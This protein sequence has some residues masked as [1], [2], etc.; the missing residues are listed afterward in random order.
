MAFELAPAA[1]IR[2]AAWPIE[3]LDAFGDRELAELVRARSVT[4]AEYERAIDRERAALWERSAGDPRF[5]KALALASPSLWQRVRRSDG[6]RARRTK[7]V[8]HLETSLYRYLA[9]AAARPT[10]A[11]LWAG[12][13]TARFGAD[14]AVTPSDGAVVFTPDLVPFASALHALEERVEYRDRARFRLSPTLRQQAD[15]SY[16]FLARA[17]GG[18][19]DLRRIEPSP[20]LGGSFDRLG[21]AGVG[22]LSELAER[23][24]LPRSVLDQLA[25]DGVLVGGLFPTS[26]ASAWEALER[27]EESLLGGDQAAWKRSLSALGQVASRLGTDFDR[28][29]AEALVLGV[30]EARTVVRGLLASLGLEIEVPSPAMH[31]DLAL[32]FVVTLG[33]ATHAELLASLTLYERERLEAHPMASAWQLRRSALAE[34]MARAPI[35]LGDELPPIFPQD[36]ARTEAWARAMLSATDEIRLHSAE[37]TGDASDNPWGSWVARLGK[38]RI[39]SATAIDESPLRPFARHAPMLGA[40]NEITSWVA[41]LFAKLEADHGV[42]AADLAVPFERNPNVLARPSVA[43]VTLEPWGAGGSDLRGA[44]FRS[45]AGAIVLDLPS[46]GRV[47]VVTSFS[48]N[49]LALDPLAAALALTGFAEPVDAAFQLPERPRATPEDAPYPSPR[50]VLSNGTSIR[51]RSTLLRGRA[52]DELAATPRNERYGRWRKLAEQLAWGPC[53]GL[54]VDGGPSLVLDASSPLAVEAAFEGARQARAILVE[55]VDVSARIRGRSGHHV[56]D[57]VVPF[58]RTPHA[59]S[60]CKG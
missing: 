39:T 53:V 51:P 29:S 48:A 8:R 1:V 9:R 56:A 10:P 43:R 26:F 12:V 30:E 36:E 14:D 59:F 2:A 18:S 47:I 20:G 58:S 11:G 27:A 60:A 21:D 28:L 25:K 23:S 33:P 55:E 41:G 24:R 49:A 22:T 37:R 16:Q 45:E 13:T 6:P 31:C 5:M 44:T 42:I 34:A 3:T 46:L 57:V 54:S 15:G 4:G 7:R 52:L 19:I 17:F 35:A 50:L 40:E 32:P 38:D